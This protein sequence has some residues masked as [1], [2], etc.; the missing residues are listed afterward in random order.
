VTLLRTVL[1]V[2]AAA[3]VFLAG[4]IVGVSVG[5]VPGAALLLGAIC[6]GGAAMAARPHR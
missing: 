2:L 6:A 4:V 5:L 1:V 3:A